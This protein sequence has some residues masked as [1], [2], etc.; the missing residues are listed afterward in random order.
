MGKIKK[1]GK[2]PLVFYMQTEEKINLQE[3]KDKI[4]PILKRAAV[5]K[6]ALFG[7]IVRGDNTKDSDIDIIVDLHKD[8]TLI[9]LVAVKQDIEEALEKEADLITYRA[10]D[11]LLKKINFG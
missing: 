10:I 3:L 7:S 9:D 5:G 4:V 11:P 1:A 2:P 8:A 6:A